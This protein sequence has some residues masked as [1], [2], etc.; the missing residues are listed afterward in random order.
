MVAGAAAMFAAVVSTAPAA[1]AQETE[2]IVPGTYTDTASVS[3]IFAG[4]ATTETFTL[5]NTSTTQSSIGSAQLTL[6]GMPTT[7][8]LGSSPVNNSN[9]SAKLSTNSSGYSVITLSSPSQGD[10]DN[11]NDDSSE[12]APN[13]SV[14]VTVSLEAATAGSI[15]V[16]SV[17]QGSGTF[18]GGP[19]W[20]LK[21]G[22]KD[23]SITVALQPQTIT[24]TSTPPASP[25]TAGTTYTPTASATSNLPVAITLGQAPNACTIDNT[26]EVTFSGTGTCT[27]D[28]NQ[29]GDGTTWAAAPQVQEVFTVVAPVL[30]FTQEPP[31]NVQQSVASSNSFTYMCPS[32]TVQLETTGGMNISASDVMVSIAV[33]SGSANPGLYF[34]GTA[35][36]A[37]GVQVPT[38]GSGAAVFG[39]GAAPCTSG[40]SATNIGP[41]F[42]LSASSSGGTTVN[43]TSF[44]VQQ[45]VQTCTSS[46]SSPTVTSTST[47]VTSSVSATTNGTF[48]LVT[49]FGQGDQLNCDSAVSSSPADPVLVLGTGGT[50]GTTATKTV[51]MVFPKSVV[52]TEPIPNAPLMAV[53]AGAN[54]P[55]PT[56]L[57]YKGST[58]DPYQGLLFA[59]SDPLYNLLAPLAPLDMCVQSEQKSTA[60]TETVVI[61]ITSQSNVDP[62]AW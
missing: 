22:T 29:G 35:V 24:F 37:S 52:Q 26:G 43:S 36:A 54:E 56:W 28:A 25:V 40:L 50:S 4:T 38:N 62:H 9:W 34:N 18:G 3:T 45:T 20:S 12:V 61:R 14:S 15:A 57:P 5:T 30:V 53:C 16:S 39:S 48:T 10:G 44:A 60:D 19:T 2:H 11:D 17:V 7:V 49:S 6:G 51:T 32:V 1:G 8:T 23:P 55:F 31:A 21:S 41:S 46:C 58:A 42:L 59:C 13:K 33:A 27:I 47:G